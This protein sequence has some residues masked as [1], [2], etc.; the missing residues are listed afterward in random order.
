MVK[1]SRL[2]NNIARSDDIGTVEVVPLLF[3]AVGGVYPHTLETLAYCPIGRTP[4]RGIVDGLPSPPDKIPPV[5]KKMAEFAFD[6]AI[7]ALRAWH[8]HG[9]FRHTS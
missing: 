5:V 2:A 6:A 3:G 1:Y 8:K 9:A 7:E 4:R